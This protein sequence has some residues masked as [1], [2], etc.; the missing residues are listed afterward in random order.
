MRKQTIYRLSIRLTEKDIDLLWLEAD[1][2]S[3]RFSALVKT[4]LRNEISGQRESIPLPRKPEGKIKTKTVGIR[5]YKNED[6][7]IADWIQRF[8]KG[9]RG[10]VVKELL[11]HSIEIFDYRPYTSDME[12]MLE[13][14]TPSES[15]WKGERHRKY[16]TAEDTARVMESQMKE[17][18]ETENE[19]ETEDDWLTAFQEMAKQ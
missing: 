1:P 7:E 4:V 9:C 17:S 16:T 11:R 8:K 2:L 13:H 3:R 5:F 19:M 14:G 10:L 15:F 18:E 6:E 12:M